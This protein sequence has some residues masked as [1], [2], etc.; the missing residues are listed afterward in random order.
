MFLARILGISMG[1]LLNSA[2]ELMLL[3]M[4]TVFVFLVVLIF[5]TRGMSAAVALLPIDE[6]EEPKAAPAPAA[7]VSNVNDPRLIKA[8][9]A[10]IKQ[11]Q[12]QS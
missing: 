7:A 11:H 8:I 2:V 1:E 9:S 10:A 12:S 6:P 4:G 3:G 5:A